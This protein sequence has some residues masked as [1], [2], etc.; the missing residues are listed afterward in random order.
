MH[1]TLHATK[2]NQTLA[3]CLD[4]FGNGLESDE[5]IERLLAILGAHYRG[6]RAFV[7]EFARETGAIV[8]AYEWCSP[9]FESQLPQLRAMNRDAFSPW[10]DALVDKHAVFIDKRSCAALPVQ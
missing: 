4:V 10:E 2:V 1:A 8:H 6:D 5:V 7:F 3:R 9:G